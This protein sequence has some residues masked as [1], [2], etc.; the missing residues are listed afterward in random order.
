MN[1]RLII[2]CSLTGVLALQAQ[3]RYDMSNL[4]RETL[5]RGVVAI[6]QDQQVV[7]SWRTLTS[8]G[9]G[10]AFD[11]YRNG[12]TVRNLTLRLSL[13]VAPFLSIPSPWQVMLPTR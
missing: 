2:A 13:R 7:V 9:V 3:P 8:D 6:R 11:V 4:C 10:E 1:R 12:A 5:D